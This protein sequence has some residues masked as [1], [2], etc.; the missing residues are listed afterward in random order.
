VSSS[1]R[2]DR[3]LAAATR[4]FD[5]VMVAAQAGGE[6]ALEALFVQ[7]QPSLLR[8]LRAQAGDDTDDIASETWLQVARGLSQ[9]KGDE[10]GFRAWLFTV[11]RNRLIDER[12][13][14]SRRPNTI[15]NNDSLASVPTRDTS[16]ED[17]VINAD[18]GDEAVRRIVALLPADQAEVILLRV[19]ADLTVDQVAEIVG[20]RP[21]AVRTMQSRGLKRLADRLGRNV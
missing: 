19:V 13:R 2:P 1:A 9:F 15:A 11:A 17:V 20:K 8:F 18:A 5:A 16:P 3:Y 6:W 14:T 7:F 21:G 12:R 10:D 4:N